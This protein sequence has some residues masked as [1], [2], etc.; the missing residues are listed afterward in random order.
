MSEK[1]SLLPDFISNVQQPS[2]DF[3][4]TGTN[5]L[6]ILSDY[7]GHI[8]ISIDFEKS[9]VE[10][11]VY[12]A[13][14]ELY[15]KLNDDNFVITYNGTP[16]ELDN[17]FKM[18]YIEKFQGLYEPIKSYIEVYITETNEYFIDFSDDTGNLFLTGSVV[19]NSTSPFFDIEDVYFPYPSGVGESVIN[20]LSFDE[21]Y[22]IMQNTVLTDYLL[23]YHLQDLQTLVF[24]NTA[25]TAHGTN[26]VT[27]NYYVDRLWGFSLTL[28]SRLSE[29]LGGMGEFIKFFKGVNYKDLDSSRASIPI[30]YTL[31]DLEGME[32]KI[33]YLK[34]KLTSYVPSLTG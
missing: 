4:G 12:K 5:L 8:D 34:R 27:D 33:D 2:V 20:K 26:L 21:R 10:V 30:R 25:I 1:V 11:D 32:A 14:A 13:T 7:L 29:I 3:Y 24:D 17:D 31:K 23:K 16:Y 6:D 19:D 28:Q 15:K 22:N 18:F 9:K